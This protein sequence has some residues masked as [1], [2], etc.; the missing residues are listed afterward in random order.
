M[1]AI[2]QLLDL[3]P[4]KILQKVGIIG[5]P[6]SVDLLKRRCEDGQLK[7]LSPEYFQRHDR[8][9]SSLLEKVSHATTLKEVLIAST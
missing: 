6:A 9:I 8:I 1:R 4:G 3:T 5:K 2:S 7:E